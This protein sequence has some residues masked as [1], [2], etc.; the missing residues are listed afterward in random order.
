MSRFSFKDVETLRETTS[1]W[2]I[3]RSI[4]A[5][6]DEEI[7]AIAA[8]ASVFADTTPHALT[9]IIRAIREFSAEIND[10]LSVDDDGLDAELFG[11]RAVQDSGRLSNLIIPLVIMS[12]TQLR[13]VGFEAEGSRAESLRKFDSALAHLTNLDADG[14]TFVVNHYTVE[15]VRDVMQ[16]MDV[17]V[18]QD[19][20]D[21]ATYQVVKQ[22]ANPEHVTD[23]DAIDAVGKWFVETF[24]EEDAVAFRDTI[25]SAV[26]ENG[27]EAR[28]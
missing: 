26:D 27:I 18:A 13:P 28:M 20:V 3:A 7:G 14:E 5:L 6:T 22:M 23:E 21:D 11:V 9:P 16:P 24:P 12:A 17:F 10:P 25:R 2:A 19:E 8:D 1:D 15:E 4:A